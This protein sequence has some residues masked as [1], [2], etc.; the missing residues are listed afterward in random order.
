MPSRFKL[1]S[2]RPHKPHKPRAYQHTKAVKEAA[3]HAHWQAREAKWL[4]T[5]AELKRY[6]E[7]QKP[8]TESQLVDLLRDGLGL[9]DE[10]P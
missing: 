5:V 1:D 2:S 4:S 10:G 7:A 8:L 9:H 6:Q 3:Y